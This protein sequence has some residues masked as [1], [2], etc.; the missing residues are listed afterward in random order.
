MVRAMW[1]EVA[2]IYRASKKK[3]DINWFTEWVC[4]PPAAL[5]VYLLQGTP[6]TPNQITLLSLVV[7]TA[8]GAIYVLLPGHLWLVVATLVFELSFVLDCVD[9]Q[10]AR[11]RNT[12]SP[13]GHLFDFL[14]DEIKALL[15]LGCVTI[16]LWRSSDDE[17]YLLAGITALFAL[18]SGMAITSLMRRPEYGARA[19]TKD[20]QPAEMKQRT[21]LVG[22]GVS[23]LEHL[24]RTIVHYPA[25]IWLAAA[26]NRI[27]LYF[28]VYGAVNVLY[29]GW[30]FLAVTW[31]LCRFPTPAA[32]TGGDE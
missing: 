21:G 4:R 22:L 8:A 6:I 2:S 28:W 17:L 16:R 1:S 11:V 9:G 25:Y 3:K 18:A 30:V 19:W 27:D 12:A 29:L 20:G 13:L 23:A 26:L 7:C 15:I 32:P 24:A 5:L 10:L 31:R 14:V